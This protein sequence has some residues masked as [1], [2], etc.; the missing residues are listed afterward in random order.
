MK[1]LSRPL[2]KFVKKTVTKYAEK[3]Q[4]TIANATVFPVNGAV[5]PLNNVAAS[6]TGNGRIGRHIHGE[7][8]RFRAYLLPPTNANFTDHLNVAL[9]WDNQG[10][11]LNPTYPQVFDQSTAGVK[12][13]LTASNTLQFPQRFK[14]LRNER[15]FL[16]NGQSFPNMIEWFV[17]LD[18]DI[19]YNTDG[20][21]INP[22][23]GAIYLVI[24]SDNNTGLTTSSSQITYYSKFIYTD[25]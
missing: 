22:T 18:K 10:D 23:K 2:R 9:V 3:K 8:I 17:K 21:T 1:V 13:G 11:G 16:Q 24:G 7:H 19:S 6:A 20:G 15:F 12:V 25:I 14:V 5:I 4:I